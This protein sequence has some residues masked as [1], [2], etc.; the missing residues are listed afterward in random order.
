MTTLSNALEVEWSCCNNEIEITKVDVKV[1]II[2]LYHLFVML[3]FGVLT[4]FLNFFNKLENIWLRAKALRSQKAKQE[5]IHFIA[6][7]LIL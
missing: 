2:V 7:K 5:W 6:I 4:F 1:R 3:L